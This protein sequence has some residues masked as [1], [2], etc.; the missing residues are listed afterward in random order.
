MM[1]LFTKTVYGQGP[2]IKY[3]RKIFRK[4]NI[5]NTLIRTH[6]CAYQE[7]RNVI[8]SENFAYVLVGWFP[9]QDSEYS[10]GIGKSSKL[11]MK[12]IKYHIQTK[13]NSNKL[14]SKPNFGDPIS[15]QLLVQLYITVVLN[16]SSKIS[17]AKI[18][19]TQCKYACVSGGK[20]CY[21]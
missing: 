5:S 1:E 20:I 19:G 10:S 7:V 21:F 15:H 2:S 12:L 18:S 13:L 16:F 11:F 14:N 6:T 3:V 9:K 17:V 4:T 8:F